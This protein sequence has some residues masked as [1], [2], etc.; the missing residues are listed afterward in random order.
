MKSDGYAP[1]GGEKK[2]SWISLIVF[3]AVLVV[4]MG[5]TYYFSHNYLIIFP[6]EGESMQNTIQDNDK[7]VLFKTTNVDYDDIIVFYLSEEDRFLIKRVIGLPGD[8]IEIRY[9]YGDSHYHVYRNGTVLRED[10]IK[11]PIERNYS[12]MKVVVPEGKIFFLGD[13]R[14]NSHDSHVGL[15]AEIKYVQGVAVAKYTDWTDF[16]FL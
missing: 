9:S 5:G 7:V 13:N 10:Y 14:N 1:I 4:V 16:K 3:V 8:E 6:V 12:D 15:L 11:E 2:F